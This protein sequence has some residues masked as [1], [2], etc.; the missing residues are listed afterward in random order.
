MHNKLLILYLSLA[1]SCVSVF[2]QN[3]DRSVIL[4]LGGTTTGVSVTYESRFKP[5]SNFGYKVGVATNLQN[6]DFLILPS[7]LSPSALLTRMETPSISSSG[8]IPLPSMLKNGKHHK[9]LSFPIGVNYLIGKGEGKIELEA[10]ASLGAYRY[11]E[12]RWVGDDTDAANDALEENNLHREDYKKT[13]FGY[14]I[15]GGA[16]YRFTS[17]SGLQFR[18]GLTPSFNFGDKYGVNNYLFAYCSVGY[19]F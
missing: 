19:A 9:S 17:P 5:G 7:M 1:A 11:Y 4:Q 14:L 10:G 3:R 2:A 18:M 6:C 13:T 12:H 16:G 8:C 15:Y